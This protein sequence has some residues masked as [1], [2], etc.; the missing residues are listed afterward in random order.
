VFVVGIT[1]GIGSGKSAVT[2]CFEALGV[3]VVDADVIARQVVSIGSPAL[4]QIHQHFGPGI[5][6]E[7]GELNRAKLRQIVFTE[8]TERR[9]LEQLTHPLI[10]INIIQALQNAPSA[11]VILVSPLLIESGQYNLCQRILVI[12]VE[13]ETQLQRTILRDNNDRQQVEAIIAAQIPRDKRLQHAHDIINNEVDISELP[14]IVAALHQ[15]YCELSTQS[16]NAL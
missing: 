13:H 9:W 3:I 1:G 4:E 6:L 10:R 14:A 7:N 16:L 2:R 11:Y 5:L 12:D 8:P 15:Q